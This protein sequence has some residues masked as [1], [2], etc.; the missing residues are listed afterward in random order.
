MA[1]R[2]NYDSADYTA[3]YEDGKEEAKKE[4]Q[5]LTEDE[6]AKCFDEVMIVDEISSEFTPINFARAIEQALKEKNHGET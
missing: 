1:Y 3:G 6:I 2:P 4:W 5:G